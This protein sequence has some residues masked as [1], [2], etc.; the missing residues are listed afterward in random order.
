MSKI[1]RDISGKEVAKMLKKFDYEITR[2]TT[3]KTGTEHHITIP[4]HNP[5]K[6]GTLNNIIQSISTYLKIPKEKLI[7]QLFED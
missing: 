3:N 6:V 1:P 2:L 4:D 7:K 5:L